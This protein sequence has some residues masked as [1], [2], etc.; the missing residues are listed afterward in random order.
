MKPLKVLVISILLL[1]VAFVVVRRTNLIANLSKVA[2]KQVQ[3]FINETKNEEDAVTLSVQSGSATVKSEAQEKTIFQGT[4]QP[5]ENGDIV[6]TNEIGIATI[7]YPGETIVRLAP[8]ST[9]TINNQET[10]VNLE[11]SAGIIFVRFKKILGVTEEVNVE[12]PTAVATIRGTKLV[13]KIDKLKTSKFIVTEHEVEVFKKDPAT[14]KKL[15]ETK[16]I[17]KENFQAQIDAKF[18]KIAKQ[19]LT[20]DEKKWIDL[21]RDELQETIIK[22]FFQSPSPSASPKAMS[23]STGLPSPSV[24]SKPVTYASQMFGAGF[25]TG[26]V[27][28]Q[29]GEFPIS[30]YGSAQGATKVITDSASESDCK[31]DCPVLPLH[32]YATRNGGVAAINGMY[33]CPADYP[34]CSDKKNSFDTL[35]FNSRVKRYLNSDNNIYSNIPFLVINSDGSP[36]FISRSLEWGRDTGIQA[37]TAGNPILVQ[38]GNISAVEGNLDEKQRTVKSNRGA[39]VQKAPNIYLCVVGSATVMDSAYVYKALGV[40]NA[41]NIDGGGSSALWVQGSYKY[42]PGRNIPTAI[43][44]K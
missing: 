6:T 40:D 27:K 36:R 2:P 9:L 11:Q 16:Q 21:N 28:T 35:F 10:T 34:S 15:I 44:F 20:D 39:F 24:T 42:G 29:T 43:I 33:F 32:E 26:R 31:T 12:T 4:T 13:S 17:L 5:L 41:I 25:S 3:E 23:T 8:N 37:G 22:T 14:R 19:S 38:G 1:L 7:K 18:I 30:C